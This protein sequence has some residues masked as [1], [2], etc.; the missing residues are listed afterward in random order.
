MYLFY[1]GK[2]LID[3]DRWHRTHIRPKMLLCIKGCMILMGQTQFDKIMYRNSK[4]IYMPQVYVM[5]LKGFNRNKML[6]TAQ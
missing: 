5:Q 2:L 6:Y 3:I 1:K 4:I